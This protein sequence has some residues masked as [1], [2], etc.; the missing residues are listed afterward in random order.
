V[1]EGGAHCSGATPERWRKG[2]TRWSSTTTMTS[3]GRR[4]QWRAPE[5]PGEGGEGEAP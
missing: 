5:V 1:T 2:A 3:G 4:R